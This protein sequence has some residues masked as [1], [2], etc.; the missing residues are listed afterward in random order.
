MQ[1]QMFT[2]WDNYEQNWNSVDELLHQCAHLNGTKRSNYFVN[3]FLNC[4]KLLSI[5]G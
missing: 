3:F 2:I 1:A 4:C 5:L